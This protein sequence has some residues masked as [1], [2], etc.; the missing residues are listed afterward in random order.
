MGGTGVLGVLLHGRLGPAAI[1]RWHLRL[2]F[3]PRSMF[4]ALFP[5]P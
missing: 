3:S 1:R 2:Q 4:I 5:K